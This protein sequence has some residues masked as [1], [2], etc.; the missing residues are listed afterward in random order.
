[1]QTAVPLSCKKKI[2]S[3]PLFHSE[4]ET[5]YFGKRTAAFFQP[6][7]LCESLPQGS[8]RTATSRLFMWFKPCIEKRGCGISQGAGLM[9]IW[10]APVRKWSLHT[11][12]MQVKWCSRQPEHPLRWF[13]EQTVHSIALKSTSCQCFETGPPSQNWMWMYSRASF[14]MLIQNVKQ[15]ANLFTCKEL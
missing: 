6:L 9:Q 11:G 7:L 12:H 10:Q 13:V 1:M 15:S 14:E 3:L 5:P 2:I 8:R 4:K